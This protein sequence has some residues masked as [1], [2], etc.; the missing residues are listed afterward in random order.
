MI[1][2]MTYKVKPFMGM[3]ERKEMMSAFATF[4]LSSHIKAHY[5]NADGTGGV[6]LND[7]PDMAESFALIQHY[8][9][10]FTYEVDV[11]LPAEEAIPSILEP[12][13]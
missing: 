3:A 12:L 5:V 10:F 9:E 8:L 11:M 4:G 6:L 2:M 7:A 1:F 13:S